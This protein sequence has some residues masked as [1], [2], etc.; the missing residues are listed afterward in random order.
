MPEDFSKMVKDLG[1]EVISSHAGVPKNPTQDIA[2]KM[3]DDH[4]KLG[5][6]Y[7][8]QPYVDEEDRKSVAGYQK[9]VAD[10]NM[11]GKVMKSNNIQFGYHNHNFEFD[12]VEGKIPYFDIF[13]KEMDKDLVIMELDLFWATK[14]G[15]NPVELF[16]KYPGRFQLFHMK[17]MHTKEAPSVITKSDD[18]VPVGTGVINFKEILAAKKTAGLKYMFVEQD[19]A[20]KGD[21]F[22]AIKTSITNL[23]G[24][25]LV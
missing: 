14:A 2:K 15:Q 22:A 23:T 20:G 18:M 1:M 16:K 4:A 24:K 6:R 5:A 17:D 13:M 7:C 25:I 3:A 9:M 8:I 21:A 11:V 10:W 12:T 19:N